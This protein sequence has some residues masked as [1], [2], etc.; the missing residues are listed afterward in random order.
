MSGGASRSSSGDSG[1]YDRYSSSGGSSSDTGGWVLQV[2]VIIMVIVWG[3]DAFHQ[4]ATEGG[5]DAWLLIW[6]VCTL[7]PM[8]LI[9][10][11]NVKWGADNCL[12]SGV[13]GI[14]AISGIILIIVELVRVVGW[15]RSL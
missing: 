13:L 15:V 6:G 8:I 14:T 10:W 11:L 3:V 2:F 9:F 4:L 1:G 12:T 7:A 5:D